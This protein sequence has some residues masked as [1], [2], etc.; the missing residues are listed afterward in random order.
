MSFENEISTVE[1]A[2]YLGLTRP[3]ILR[4]IERG[5]LPSR[6]VGPHYRLSM[7]AVI[8]YGESV[9]RKRENRAA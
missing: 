2:L 8:A 6:M 4:L 5:V 9:R 7:S 3:F 1:A